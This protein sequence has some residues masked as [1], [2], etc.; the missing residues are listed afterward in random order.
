MIKKLEI[1]KNPNEILRKISE[2]IDTSEL[3]NPEFL[4]FVKS[5]EK[6]MKMANGAGLAAPQVGKNI[7]L[8]II[9]QGEKSLVMIN[10]QITKKSWSKKIEDEGCLSVVDKDGSLYYKKVARHKKVNCSYIDLKAKKRKISAE[11]LL[12]K[13]IQHEIDHLDG[14]LFI[15]KLEK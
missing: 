8:I 9:N 12:S 3:K 13:A 4:K 10:P 11:G 1:L 14:I 2:E 7:R 15:D 6:T 5:M